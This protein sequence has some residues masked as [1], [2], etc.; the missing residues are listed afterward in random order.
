MRNKGFTL[1]ELLVV[2]AI[3]AILLGI[4]VPGLSMA[5]DVTRRMTC[6]N[7]L[8]QIG[9]TMKIYAE[10]YKGKLPLNQDGWWAWDVAFATTDLVIENGGDKRTFYCPSDKS[11]GPERPEV[12]QF[13]LIYGAPRPFYMVTEPTDIARRRQEFRVTGYFWLMDM[14]NSNRPFQIQGV[15]ARKWTRDF[16]DLRNAGSTELITDATLSSTPDPATATFVEVQ[17]GS[18]SWHQTYDRTNHVNKKSQPI[19]GNICY[20]DGHADWRRWEDMQLR[21]PSNWLPSH[22]W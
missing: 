18:F 14:E 15:P 20:A 22:W 4:L 16:N 12:W 19:G 5:K 9:L 10:E 11:K 2:I 17:G 13:S 7:H 6:R 8:K 21:T 1:I 3:V